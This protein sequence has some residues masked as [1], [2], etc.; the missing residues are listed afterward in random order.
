LN[1]KIHKELK[2]HKILAL[3]KYDHINDRFIVDQDF[4]NADNFFAGDKKTVEAA[5]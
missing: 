3:P 1:Y 2:E 5:H 4:P